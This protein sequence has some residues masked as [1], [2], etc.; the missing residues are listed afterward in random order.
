MEENIENK[1]LK[2]IIEAILFAAGRPVNIQELVIALEISK[3]QIEN[4]IN[5][6][7]EDFDIRGIEI[8]KMEDSYQ[9]S[10]KKEYY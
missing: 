9:L 7:Q 3:E 4:I 6:M 2:A 10:S 8:I 5:Q 1:N